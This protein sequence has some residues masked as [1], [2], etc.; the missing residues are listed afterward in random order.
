LNTEL[1]TGLEIHRDDLS[2]LEFE[3]GYISQF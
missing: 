1:E 3:V 2:Q